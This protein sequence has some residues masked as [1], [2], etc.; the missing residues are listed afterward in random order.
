[1]P[2]R[3]I[4]AALTA[5]LI[6]CHQ[7]ARG[8]L[9][10]DPNRPF[11]WLFDTGEPSST[12]LGAKALAEG[13]LA[14]KNGWT[15]VEADNLDHQ[16]R[17]DAVLLN[18]RLAVVLR[19]Q[20]PGAEVYSS[21]DGRRLNRAVLAALPDAP[22]P[23]SVT[24][25]D[26]IKIVENSPGAVVV[27]ATFETSAE[28]QKSSATFSITTGQR[29]VEMCPKSG[30]DRIF[31][32][33][34]PQWVVVPDFLGHD[35]VFD[36]R[37]VNS[38]RFGL[39]TENFSLGLI[40]GNR[41]M[42]MCVWESGRRRSHLIRPKKTTD[43]TLSGY[44]IEVLDDEPVWFAFFEGN[45]LWHQQNL[46]AAEQGDRVKLDFQPPFEAGWRV[47]LVKPDGVALSGAFPA[48][49]QRPSIWKTRLR[50]RSSFIPWL[51]L[52]PRPF[53]PSAPST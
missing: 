5:A 50:C 45:N 51:G 33:Y 38:N 19:A 43:P 37:T 7:P 46:S 31:A 11:T 6:L 39:P 16:F 25:L 12:P 15:L 52:A 28:G 10:Y 2:L 8:Q 47:D 23:I 22:T 9:E 34:R 44:E 42:M 48:T 4:I 27:R 20:G 21:A 29:M 30:A 49:T 36:P 14:G 53:R 17:G 1:M 40:H 26:S 18:D 35:M 24:G 41:A 32:W 3:P 13:P